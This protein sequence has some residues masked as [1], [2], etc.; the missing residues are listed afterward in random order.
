[1]EGARPTA[2]ICLAM[3]E[4]VNTEE[5]LLEKIHRAKED[6]RTAVV[7]TTTNIDQNKGY[8][9]PKSAPKS[10]A[11]ASSP[12]ASS[13][14]GAG[15]YGISPLSR[16]TTRPSEDAPGEKDGK[17]CSGDSIAAG[18]E[19]GQPEH[20]GAPVRHLPRHVGSKLAQFMTLM[21]ASL[22]GT[23]AAMTLDGRDFLWEVACSENSWLAEEA[24][25]KG[26]PAPRVNYKN[27][28]DIYD[29]STWQRLRK[30][31]REKRP[32]KI[33]LSVPCTKW[34]RFA[35]LNYSTPE[36]REVLETARRKERRML[37]QAN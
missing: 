16:G 37:Q 15:R 28:Y 23:T 10:K 33:W 14:T 12:P 29:P 32:K 17:H 34:C 24:L 30:L 25:Q 35:P 18:R 36:R 6:T 5:R 22:M 3:M 8:M 13:R 20:G 27:G 31:Q 26:L 11:A 4:K 9:T 19:H 2:S 21:T 7:T 1:M